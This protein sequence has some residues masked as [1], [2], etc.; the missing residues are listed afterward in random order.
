MHSKFNC[1]FKFTAVL[2]VLVASPVLTAP[3][4]HGQAICPSCHYAGC[5]HQTGNSNTR[6]E[7]GSTGATIDDLGPTGSRFIATTR[8]SSTATD[9]GGLG[10]GDAT[11]ITWSL[12]PD[13]TNIPGEGLS[14]LISRFDTTFGSGPGGSDLTQRPWFTYFEQSFDR[15]SQLGG[16]TYVYEPNDNGS[17][18]FGASGSLGNRGDVR[19]A[20]NFV[21]GNSGTLAYNAFPND[22]DMVLDTG[23]MAFYGNSSNNFRALRNVIMHEHGHGLGFSHVESSNARFLMEP[24]IDTS[25]DGPQLDDIRA[26]HR[27]YGDV[28]EKNGGNDSVST[29]TDLGVIDDSYQLGLDASTG[30]FVSPNDVDFVSIDDNSD[31]DYFAFTVTSSAELDF[32]LIPIGPTYN[33]GA[34]GGSQSSSNTSDDSNLGFFVYDT[35]GTSVLAIGNDTT[36]GNQEAASDVLL[37]EAGTYYARIVGND[38]AMQFY[39]MQIAIDL[40]ETFLSADFNTDGIVNLLDLDILGANYNDSGTLTET[41]DANGDGVTNLL[42]LDIL[43]TQ[44]QQSSSFAEAL[45]AA[46]IVPEPATLGLLVIGGVAASRRRRAA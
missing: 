8:W 27:Q 38:N 24:F 5:N 46:G 19:I 1:L 40:I 16:V 31:Q 13:G 23:D 4:A 18:L 33:Q 39:A 20:G 11:T 22:G 14:D 41:G 44:W 10:Q 7:K 6:D 36:A 15:W 32:T 28:Y 42:D 2:A 17:N 37:P 45:A 34:Q 3:A 9:G 43:G 29:A 12:A 26:L 35:D 30:T 21:D 25:F